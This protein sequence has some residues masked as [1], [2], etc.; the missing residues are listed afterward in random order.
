MITILCSG[1]RGDIQPYIALALELQ[2]QGKEVRICTGKSFEKFITGYGIGFTSISADLET[3]QGINPELMRAA[4]SSDNPLKML[5]TFR[6]M[7]RFAEK[8]AAAMTEESVL[9]CMGSELIVYHPGCATGYFAARQLGVPAVLATPFPLHRTREY[10][11]M[12]AYGRYPLLLKAVSYSLLQG[13]LW[14]VSRNAVADYWKRTFGALPENFGC[15]YEK[16]SGRYPAVASC[17]GAVFP[18]PDDW[19]E[20]IHQSGYWFLNETGDYQPPQALAEFLAAGEMPVYIGFG[21]VLNQQ[22]GEYIS[23]IA[24]EALQKTG[25]RGILCGFGDVFG[26]PESVFS[27]QSVPHSWLFGK[28]TAVCHHGGAGTT[29]AGFAAGVPSFIIPFSNDQ[30]AWA[31]R[32]YDL[33]VAP[34]PFSKKQLTAERLADALQFS[35]REDVRSKAAALGASVRAEHGTRDAVAVILS[36]LKAKV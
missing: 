1:S 23:H 33:G 26:L 7:K 25:M 4:Q 14:S 11:S 3:A 36:A 13:M 20:N 10:A 6:K 2:K 27:I 22:E 5:L 32:A 15:P 34:K 8:V 17:S 35:Q 21:S 9:A 16:V 29:A 24:V 18:R 28:V 30:F 31:H 12:V 19:D